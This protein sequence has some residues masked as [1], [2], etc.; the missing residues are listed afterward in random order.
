M[1]KGIC[2]LLSFIF[3]LS[4]MPFAIFANEVSGEETEELY[5]VTTSDS[6]LAY[7]SSEKNTLWTPASALIDGKYSKD[8][9]QGWEV[10]YPD[11]IYG[12]D[13]SAGFSGQYFGVKFTNKEYYEIHDVYINLGL[14]AAMGG[15]NTHFVVQFLVEGVWVTVKEFSDSDTKP[16]SYDTYEDAMKNDTSFYHIPAEIS[17]KLDA[18][19]TT[20]NVRVTISEYGKNYPG[21]DVL[22]FPY[23]YE[24]VL[25][26]KRGETPELEL[27]E[28]AIVST[29]IGY[30]SYPEASSSVSYRYPYCAIDG[31]D[32]T[33]WSPRKKTAGENLALVF[34]ESKKI[35]KVVVNFGKYQGVGNNTAH[36][37]NIEALVDVNWIV[38]ASENSLSDEFVSFANI[39][40]SIIIEIPITEV[41]T[42]AVRI[43]F[44]EKYTIA[45]TVYE[46]EAHMSIDKTYYVE[47]RFDVHQRISASKGNIALVATPYASKDFVPYSDVNYIIDGQKDKDSYVWFTGVI[48]MPSYCGLKFDKKYTI[49]RIALY[50]FVPEKEGTDIMNIQ[51][52]AMIDGEYKT[53]FE[54]KSYHKD[55]KYSPAFQFDPVETDDIRIVYTAGSGTFAHLKEIELFSPNGGLP[56]FDGLAA[57][58]SMP[59]FI[60]LRSSSEEIQDTDNAETSVEEELPKAEHIYYTSTEDMSKEQT[61]VPTPT[62]QFDDNSFNIVICTVT[63]IVTLGA[64]AIAVAIKKRK[65]K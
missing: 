11:I 45:P 41:D 2:L 20:N 13:T 56:M 16:L 31:K 28:G 32:T 14:H 64:I 55:L 40:D 10:G 42:T 19:I 43:V 17:F 34:A 9:W 26:G 47:D 22:I 49:D 58:E 38:Y 12:S 3:L 30:H 50:F 35:N 65:Q 39:G 48:D 5:N 52:Q 4:C 57:M 1:R 29:N 37:F 23:V 21:G 24:I 61:T 51:I 33:Y 36:D 53:I 60:D 8:T 54:T 18:P 59:E 46:F 7:S 25:N 27:P 6:A 63:I 44:T 62:S 15:Q